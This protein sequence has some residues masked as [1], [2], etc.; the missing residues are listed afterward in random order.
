M[1]L[2][3][4]R[5]HAHLSYSHT[6]YHHRTS[7]LSPAG[8]SEKKKRLNT[9]VTR[10]VKYMCFIDVTAVRLGESNIRVGAEACGGKI[11]RE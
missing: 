1:G 11:V 9:V 5:D 3:P 8:A 7:C 4:D 6:R 2:A 10:V